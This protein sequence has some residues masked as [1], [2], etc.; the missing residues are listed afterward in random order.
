MRITKG[1]DQL[2]VIERRGTKSTGRCCS[3]I[4]VDVTLC[5]LS[6]QLIECI[7]YSLSA[8]EEYRLLALLLIMVH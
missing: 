3:Q 1:F 8:V 6:L 4:D 2:Y 7:N 5:N